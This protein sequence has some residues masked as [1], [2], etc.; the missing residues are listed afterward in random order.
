MRGSLG[1]VKDRLNKIVAESVP[2]DGHGNGH[3][4]NGHPAEGDV[5]HAAIGAPQRED[6]DSG[7]HETH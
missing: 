6:A 4:P 2:V 7:D 1:R 3:H 5:E